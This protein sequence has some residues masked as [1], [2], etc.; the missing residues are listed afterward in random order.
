M[1][2]ID[3]SRI[4]AK[5]YNYYLGKFGYKFLIEFI[6][7]APQDDFYYDKVTQLKRQFQYIEG[8]RREKVRYSSK[9]IT[10][11]LDNE[12]NTMG[13]NKLKAFRSFD[14]VSLIDFIGEENFIEIFHLFIVLDLANIVR[15]DDY[16]EYVYRLL[17]THSGFYS[18]MSIVSDY[19]SEDQE[20]YELV[21]DLVFET[22]EYMTHRVHYL[23]PI[24]ATFE[25]LTGRMISKTNMNTG[26]RHYYLEEYEVDENSVEL[27]K[28][29]H[30]HYLNLL[31]CM[32]GFKRRLEEDH[33]I[34]GV[35]NEITDIYCNRFNIERLNRGI[36][37]D[38]DIDPVIRQIDRFIRHFLAFYEPKD[39]NIQ[40]EIFNED[41]L[42]YGSYHYYFSNDEGLFYNIDDFIANFI[43]DVYEVHHEVKDLADVSLHDRIAM[44]HLERTARIG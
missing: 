40:N 25:P 26:K 18:V 36:Y 42:G 13:L 6:N 33:P 4:T 39:D 41:P 37:H 7:K 32:V 27:I 3:L 19:I 8:D 30:N 24:Y 14:K 31:D 35:L 34:F 5:E 11:A 28:L 9:S 38:I 17:E 15:F 23:Q 29:E 10:K 12:Y 2:N 44:D 16:P 1:Y 22:M 43:L 20:F 21:D